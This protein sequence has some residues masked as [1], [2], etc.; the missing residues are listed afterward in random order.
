[1]RL[2]IIIKAALA[3]AVGLGTAI[4]NPALAKGPHV[5]AGQWAVDYAK[6]VCVLSR[7]GTGAEPGIAIR[8]RP[9]SNE[10]DLLLYLPRTGEKERWVQAQLLIDGRMVG[11]Q[12]FVAIGEPTR[13]RKLIDTRISADE[14]AAV[15][16]AGTIRLSDGA[17][18]DVTVPLRNIAKAMTA[19]RACE[20]E[21]A[22]RWGVAAPEMALWITT[23]LPETDLRALFWNKD[24][25]KS[26]ILRTPV[27][28]LLDIDE[29]GSVTACTITQSS[30]V[31]WVD[32]R[33]CETLR[34][35]AKFRPA[36]GA[37]GNP[38]S[39]KYVTPAITSAIIRR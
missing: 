21:L 12:R 32:T 30:R 24:P 39:G 35:V 1:M 14:L 8:T 2:A 33:F 9:F 4:G 6:E 34:T 17:R 26:V 16:V 5:P 13:S 23:A 36:I 20:V 37:S 18:L 27:R 15:A 19:L 38:V 31:S 29:R 22:G 28:A 25:R 3:G 7:D 10:H 11:A